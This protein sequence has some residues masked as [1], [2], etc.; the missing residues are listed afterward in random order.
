M[1][2]LTRRISESIYIDDDICITVL[3]VKGH[4][5]RL[6]LTAPKDVSI[7]RE[8]IYQ[9]IQL[10]KERKKSETEPQEKESDSD[11]GKFRTK[12]SGTYG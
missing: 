10:E 12:K 3:G 9:R 5:V 1:L 4:Q 2:I 6:G 8:E 7:H 11:D